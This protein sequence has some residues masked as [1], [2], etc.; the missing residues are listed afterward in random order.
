[1]V[2]GH[3]FAAHDQCQGGWSDLRT[4]CEIKSKSCGL[5]ARAQTPDLSRESEEARDPASECSINLFLLRMYEFTA[6]NAVKCI[7]IASVSL[8]LEI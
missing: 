4:A 2:S 7:H 3:E 6:Y 5:A 1:M 8:S